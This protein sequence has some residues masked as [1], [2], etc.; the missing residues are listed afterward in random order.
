M[1]T[2]L[3]QQI[4]SIT[5]EGSIKKE[6]TDKAFTILG[7]AKFIGMPNNESTKRMQ[8]TYTRWRLTP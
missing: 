1:G 4:L 7:D 6:E 2:L 5:N 8:I 3:Y